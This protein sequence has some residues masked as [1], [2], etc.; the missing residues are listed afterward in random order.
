MK[1][2]KEL[3]EEL[4]ASDELN[5]GIVSK[6]L[7]W[8][9]GQI[10]K[11]LHKILD[12]LEKMTGKHVGL[13]QKSS[14]PSAGKDRGNEF[15][16]FKKEAEDSGAAFFIVK[17]FTP[18]AFEAALTPVLAHWHGSYRTDGFSTTVG[19]LKEKASSAGYSVQ[20]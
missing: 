13:V 16:K 1:T 2:F 19:E 10:D 3:R 4:N 11:G 6:L 7:P 12:K 17:P 15:P 9:T 14:I 8:T 20:V 5:E 18:N